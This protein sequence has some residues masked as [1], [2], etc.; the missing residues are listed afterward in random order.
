[1]RLKVWRVENIN[2]LFIYR[3][4]NSVSGK[5]IT[6]IHYFDA[7]R[8]YTFIPRTTSKNMERKVILKRDYQI[9]PNKSLYLRKV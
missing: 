7:Q 9:I 1:M 6:I 2:N 4:H 3:L 5:V 8:K